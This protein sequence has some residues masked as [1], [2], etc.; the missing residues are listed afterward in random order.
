MASRHKGLFITVEGGEGSGKTT[1]IQGL[2]KALEHKGLKVL[3]TREPG[4]T[5]LGDKLRELLLAKSE[6]LNVGTYA[7]LFMFLASRSQQIEEVIQPAL[8]RGDIVICDR[9]N[10]STVA[11]QGKARG[12]GVENVRSLCMVAC[13]GL[14]PDFTILLDIDPVLGLERSKKTEKKESALGGHDR[15][16]SE[17]LDFHSTVREALLAEAKRRLPSALI[18]DAASSKESALNQAREQIERILP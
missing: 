3:A 8:V 14:I 10:D 6:G 9:F 18:I 15:I 11:Y 1:L 4:G 5:P 17:T 12:L 16:E 2:T 7:E 13:Q